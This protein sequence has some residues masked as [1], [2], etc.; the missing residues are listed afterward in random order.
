MIALPLSMCI[1]AHR[2]GAIRGLRGQTDWLW[3]I[4]GDLRMSVSLEEEEAGRGW[5]LQLA[6]ALLDA[7]MGTGLGGQGES[8]GPFWDNY[9]VAY[10]PS[11]EAV[12]VPFC[13]RLIENNGGEV[14]AAAGRMIQNEEIAARLQSST[15][16]P[17]SMLCNALPSPL[18]WAFA[19]VRSRCIQVDEDWFGLLPQPLL[20]RTICLRATRDIAAEEEITISY[21]DNFANRRLFSQY[22]FVLP[23]NPHDRIDW[24]RIQEEEVSLSE[25]CEEVLN[26]VTDALRSAL[27][28]IIVQEEDDD[29]D[30]SP[31]DTAR[32]NELVGNRAM[33][34][35]ASLARR[36]KEIV[37]SSQEVTLTSS[38]I[39]AG[40]KDDLR[41]LLEAFPTTL[42][43]DME[44]LA[45][46]GSGLTPFVL[47]DTGRDTTLLVGANNDGLPS[48]TVF[49]EQLKA[50]LFQRMER[51]KLLLAALAVLSSFF[52]VLNEFQ[53]SSSQARIPTIAP[54]KSI[55]SKPT[56]PTGAPTIKRSVSQNPT[57]V[58]T[59]SK[60]SVPTITLTQPPLYKKPSYPSAYKNQGSGNTGPQPTSAPTTLRPSPRPTISIAYIAPIP[61]QS[62]ARRI[63]PT[64]T[65]SGP[66]RRPTVFPTNPTAR[67]SYMPTNPTRRPTEEPTYYPTEEPTVAATRKK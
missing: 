44:I 40:M 8:D 49:R 33:S 54:T 39:L 47:S 14:A 50:S 17:P 18:E 35:S 9:C 1:L 13:M 6:L 56:K 4:C 59:R 30:S 64:R 57:A 48:G 24:P 16:L 65:P 51:K 19:L 32:F 21:G 27:M 62:N 25:S 12:T 37:I 45:A 26:A 3:D 41:K 42:E 52:A 7:S 58:P 10:L 53:V 28:R 66:S 29:L 61:P 31:S 46:V 23:E 11:P 63:A 67:P 2:S 60:T 22:G 20:E 5:D 55:A 34:L 36:A 38:E 43:Q 15:S